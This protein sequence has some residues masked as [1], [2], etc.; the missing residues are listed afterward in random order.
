ML[1]YLNRYGITFLRHTKMKLK[2]SLIHASLM[3]AMAPALAQTS[4][5]H[6]QKDE[7]DIEK[8]IVTATPLNRTVLESATPVTVLSGEKLD[9]NQAATLGETLKNTPGVHS[10]YFGPVS[11]SPII[12][13]LD[14]PRIKVVQNGLDS[15]D[16]S[17]VGPDHLVATEAFTAT[18]IEVLRG[19]ATLLYGS[20][21]IGGVVNVVDNRIPKQATEETTGELIFQH[22]TVSDGQTIALDL[23]GGSGNFA[24]HVDAFNRDTD[25]YEIPGSAEAEELHEAEGHDEH[26]EQTGEL[27]NSS[28]NAQGFTLGGGWVT[29]DYTLALSYGRLESDY[30]I[31]GHSHAEEEHEE[32][33]HEGE[34]E[35]GEEQVLGQLEQDRFQAMVDWK[36]LTG[37][38]SEVH[39]HTAYTDYEHREIE[40]G[41]VGTTFENDTFESRLWSKHKEISG[42][43]GILGVHYNKIDFS[44]LGEE[45]FTPASK[46]DSLALFVLEE[47]QQGDLLWQ[48]GGRFEHTSISPDYSF[49]EHQHHEGEEEEHEINFSDQDYNAV[50]FSAGVVWKVSDQHRWALNFA[51]SERAPSASEIFANGAHIGTQTFEIGGG[52]EIHRDGDEVEL[53]QRSSEMEKETSNNIDLTYRYT[54]NE[55]DFSL[56][57]FYNQ[58]DDYIF[59]E[60][61]GLFAMGGVLHAH[62]GEEHHEE[63][64]HE[65]PGHADEHGHGEEELPVFEYRQQDAT[66]YGFEAELD[67]HLN[68]NWR[69]SAFTDYIRAE[70]D[71][72]TNVPRIPPLRFG[73]ELHW[74][75]ESWHAEVGVTRY[76]KQDKISGFES[77]TDGY[78]LVSANLNYYVTWG[79]ADVTVFV[80]G[81]N[82]TDEEARVHS[83]FLKNLAPLPGRNISLGFKTQF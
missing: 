74:E 56:S 27:A 38:F 44:A 73:S 32:E 54:G 7:H 65:E 75:N 10:S 36:N 40:D 41:Q 81:E 19:P 71:D 69:L 47:K 25:N 22:D 76:S 70:L 9:K 72:D 4:D 24:W 8:V 82:L 33:E 17:R 68:D 16:A 43:Q 26:E 31:P 51:H 42:W 34:E 64:E 14:G 12:R 45:A 13:G 53:E 37:M 1:Y 62:E 77:K 83:S 50:S 59:Q 48:L 23:N 61:T 20:G 28:T 46:T 35:H 80:K 78:T 2:Y 5:S 60:N 52:F 67:Y 21:A 6:K 55:V 29:D 39:W 18:Q 15:S 66:L 79:D 58:V 63:E 57:L 11:S 30:G 3:L 49:F